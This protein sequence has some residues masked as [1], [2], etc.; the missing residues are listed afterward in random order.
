M[1]DYIKTYGHTFYFAMSSGERKNLRDKQRELFKEPIK[2]QKSSIGF[3]LDVCESI[4]FR[5]NIKKLERRDQANRITMFEQFQ[6]YAKIMVNILNLNEKLQTD[7][8][9]GKKLKIEH[10]NNLTNSDMNN[11]TSIDFAMRDWID[12]TDYMLSRICTEYPKISNE[13]SDKTKAK[14]WGDKEPV[15]TDPYNDENIIRLDDSYQ[16]GVWYY[17]GYPLTDHNEFAGL[18]NMWRG[19]QTLFGLE[20]RPG[21]YINIFNRL[22]NLNFEGR[23]DQTM[24]QHKELM[25]SKIGSEMLETVKE[26]SEF[27]FTD[28]LEL[29]IQNQSCN[30]SYNKLQL[31]KGKSFSNLV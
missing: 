13:Y 17:T 28:Y 22:R 24:V 29:E 18:S 2:I 19:V 20:Y 10:L 14:P 27:S 11:I 21:F 8:H 6:M 7:N 26:D 16:P 4:K 5:N 12:D 30:L 9:S 3:D 25:L 23:R 15:Y 1:N 31:R